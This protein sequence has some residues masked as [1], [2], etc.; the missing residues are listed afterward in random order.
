MRRRRVGPASEAQTAPA[1]LLLSNSPVLL[2]ALPA[3]WSDSPAHPDSLS[4]RDIDEEMI[5]ASEAETAAAGL[6]DAQ[7]M[8]LYAHL[9]DFPKNCRRLRCWVNCPSGRLRAARCVPLLRASQLRA[10]LPPKAD[11]KEQRP[12]D[13]RQAHTPAA[14]KAPEIA[15]WQL[16]C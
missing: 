13:G 7:E 5:P 16:S 4:D 8:F 2:Q 1:P 15:A 3:G 11:W 6:P 12:E 10:A 14:A 9:Q